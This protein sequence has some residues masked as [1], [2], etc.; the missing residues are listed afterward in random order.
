[1][2]IDSNSTAYVAP[3]GPAVLITHPQTSVTTGKV[4]TTK[5]R[6]YESSPSFVHQP[7]AWENFK[8]VSHPP[9]SKPLCCTSII[10][11]DNINISLELITF[12]IIVPY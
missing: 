7:I 8:L 6:L 12:G 10:S 9:N 1:M 5:R 2:H 11:Y 4:G 3:A